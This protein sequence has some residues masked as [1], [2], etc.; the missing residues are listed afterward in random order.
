LL[1]GEARIGTANSD[2]HRL[3]TIVGLPR[4]Y[5]QVANDTIEGFDRRAFI[6]SLRAGRVIGS[7]GPFLRVRLDDTGVGGLHPGSSGTLQV[8]VDAAPWVPVSE[9][10]VYVNGALV[11]RAP[12]RAGE[13]ASLP[14]HFERDGF[15]T[16]EVQGPAEGLYRDVLRGFTPFAFTNPIFVD[17]DGNGRFDASGLPASLPPSLAD[18]DR[19][20]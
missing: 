6:E 5:V 20:D 8:A 1:Q 9:W 7:T 16:V 17:A 12:I 13:R 19:A 15:V 18:P 14:L 11:H 4:N 10:R 2:S 3:G